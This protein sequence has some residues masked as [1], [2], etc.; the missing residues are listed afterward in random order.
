MTTVHSLRNFAY[1]GLRSVG[2]DSGGRETRHSVC[3]ATR[4]IKKNTHTPNVGRHQKNCSVAKAMERRSPPPR[5]KKKKKLSHSMK[6]RCGFYSTAL[7]TSSYHTGLA[8]TTLV[9]CRSTPVTIAHA[10][11]Y[12]CYGIF[13]WHNTTKALR[14]SMLTSRYPTPVFLWRVSSASSYFDKRK[15]CRGPCP[16]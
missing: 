10:M 3:V 16:F 1:E 7:S 14:K 9:F 4:T 6:N 5:K 11:Y 12:Y 13:L 15:K 8:R 2:E